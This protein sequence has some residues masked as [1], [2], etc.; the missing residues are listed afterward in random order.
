MHLRT[1]ALGGVVLG[2]AMACASRPTALPSPAEQAP[3]VGVTRPEP[4]E[5]SADASFEPVVDA[6]REPSDA[7]SPS[8]AAD[9]CRGDAF[10]LD[11]LP[12]ECL[13]KK[14]GRA[15]AKLEAS[16]TVDAPSV[17][18][19]SEIGVT[20]TL[21]NAS[22]DAAEIE[23]STGC[24]YLSVQA[25][26]GGKRADEIAACGYGRGCGGG[27]H[28]L[29][30]APRGKLTKHFRY[31]ARVN[32]QSPKDCSWTE[33]PLAAGRYELRVDSSE[34]FAFHDAVSK[35]RAPLVV[36]R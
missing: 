6:G 4:S 13:G 23:V 24:A 26:Q 14:A 8:I 29:V 28:H 2:H 25:F 12:K 16:L 7:A 34:S 20:M 10:D 35:L 21:T 31:K 33:S 11:A 36:T 22:A 9:P 18:G 5:A 3:I 27:Y 30:L 32:K 15:A 1:L 17:R 19:G